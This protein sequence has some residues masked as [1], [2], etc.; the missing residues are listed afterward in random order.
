M[1]WVRFAAWVAWK[2]WKEHTV[3][4]LSFIA[5]WSVA[6]RFPFWLH[7]A[8]LGLG[9]QL[10][11]DDVRSGLQPFWFTKPMPRARVIGVKLGWAF[12]WLAVSL[13]LNL[14]IREIFTKAMFYYPAMRFGHFTAGPPMGLWETFYVWTQ[15]LYWTAAG[16]MFFAW[17][18]SKWTWFWGFTYAA[19]A[20]QAA[21]WLGNFSLSAE[22]WVLLGGGGIAAIGAMAVWSC[23]EL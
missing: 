2:E 6:D 7:L 21:M 9:Y 23:R 11:M 19:L 13:M 12:L 18:P 14:L 15:S 16:A 10:V 4:L 20:I 22:P 3:I 8:A 17:R 1:R 5:L